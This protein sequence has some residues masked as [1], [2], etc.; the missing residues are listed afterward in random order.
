MVVA[1]VSVVLFLS[2]VGWIQGKWI[3]RLQQDNRE[4]AARVICL[5]DA[6]LGLAD[7]LAREMGQE[8]EPARHLS[9]VPDE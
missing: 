6:A 3:Q 1:L 4:L 7:D 2:I 5:S 9:V 8:P